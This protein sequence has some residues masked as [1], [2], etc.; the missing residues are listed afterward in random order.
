MMSSLPR[1]ARGGGGD[2]AFRFAMDSGSD[3]AAGVSCSASGRRFSRLA[4]RRRWWRTR[5]PARRWRRRWIDAGRPAAGGGVR[6]G[7]GFPVREINRDSRST[8]LAGVRRD[9]VR[10]I[11]RNLESVCRVCYCSNPP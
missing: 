3:A 9:D 4:R 2:F 6:H 10:P 8:Q 11:Y 7:L 1:R 5:K